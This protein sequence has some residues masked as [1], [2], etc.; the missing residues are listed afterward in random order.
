MKTTNVIK[1]CLWLLFFWGCSLSVYSQNEYISNSR[2]INE[3]HI[4]DLDGDCGI[5]LISSHD[6]LV[7]SLA[8]FERENR[9]LMRVFADGQRAD[10]LYEYR[11]LTTASS[12]RNLKVKVNRAG[13]VYQT[14]F[15]CVVKPD[16]LIAYRIEEVIKPI[17]EDDQTA[18]ND[19]LTDETAAEIEIIA[20][21]QDMQGL[22]IVYPVELQAK[23]SVKTNS[24]D[25]SIQVTSIIIPI[26]VLK[27]AEQA[28]IRAGEEYDDWFNKLEQDENM[29]EV[30]RNWEQLEQLEQQRDAAAAYYAELT[31]MEIYADKTNHLMIDISDLGPR[32]KKRYA[33]LP[34]KIEKKVYV[35][36]GA[37][38]MDEG[39]R[40]FAMRKYNNAKEAF[41]QA[42]DCA[43]VSPS[44]KATLE[45]SIMQCDTCILYDGLAAKALKEIMR[46]KK[47]GNATQ[48]EMTK[49]ASA[50][51]EFLQVL[52]NNNPSV[53]YTKRIVTLEN[54]LASQ[55]LFMRFTIVEWKTLY[56]GNKIPNVEVWAYKGD[57]KLPLSVYNSDR[58]FKKIIEKQ[59]AFF[60]QIGLSDMEGIV[61]F[62]FNRKE[63]PT[64]IF[65]RPKDNT[66]IKIK[67]MNMSELQRQSNGDF[68]KRQVRLKMFTK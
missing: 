26:Q 50:G 21:I 33:I 61:E 15:T 45:G 47:D 37:A 60:E 2:S 13:N 10:G 43:D 64:G 14:E 8:Q 34:L 32:S 36:Q 52:A 19:L 62:E 20:N 40:L 7:I 38:Y 51:I 56:E 1:T 67:Y 35:T 53:F 55:P 17:R 5:L 16:Y 4:D 31:N 46:M 29:A 48:E 22:Q 3:D 58:K 9:D 44:M 6:D 54:V 42:K 27:N 12:S 68:I 65:F 66:K 24:V 39:A 28:M 63:L 11:V 18:A 23:R 57:S 59:G 30:D 41:M 49:V 25:A